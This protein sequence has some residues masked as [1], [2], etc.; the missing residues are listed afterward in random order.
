MGLVEITTPPS[1]GVEE[2]T[3]HY[4]SNLELALGVAE[5]GL[6]LYPLGTYPLPI[7][8]VSATTPPTGSRP[9]FSVVTGSRT[10]A[11]AP[12]RTCTWSCPPAPSGPT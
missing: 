9:A 2:I 5:L 10:R 8:P 12:G 3:S 1:H 11:G 4:L 7:S 6:A